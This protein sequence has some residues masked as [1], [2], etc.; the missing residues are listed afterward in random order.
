MSTST[1]ATDAPVSVELP[2]VAIVGRPNVGKSA[3]FNR[4]VGRRQAIVEDLPGTTRDRLYSEVEWRDAHFRVIDTGGLDTTEGAGYPALIRRQVEVAVAEASLLLF[5]VDV[6]DGVLAGDRDVAEILRR[7]SK[8]VFLLV[9]KV[10]NQAREEDAV[11]FYELGLGEPMQLSAQHS[12]GIA[13]V[14][15]RI[16]SSL[17]AP[18]EVLETETL[19]VAIVGR[20]NVG[21]SMLLNA[22]LGEDRV[23]VSPE[24][25]TT[26]DAIDTPFDFQGR[27]LSLIDTAGLRRPGKVREGLEHHASMRARN[28]LDR[29]DT[30]LVVFDASE[31]LTAQ[32][33]HVVGFALKAKTGV[34][35]VANKWDLRSGE[36]LADF[37][38]EVKRK[39]KFAS[40]ASFRITSAKERQGIPQLL[41]E[42]VR[43]SDERKKR[44]DTGQLNSAVQR[45]MVE[46]PP[47]MVKNRRLNLLYVTQ[48]SVAPPLFVFFVNDASLVHFSYRRYLENVLRDKF[49]F[50]GVALRLA[51]RSRREK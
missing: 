25:G 40:W 23:L 19:R 38:R 6:K 32:D 8:P 12:T 11:Q 45:A 29:A 15:D 4:M 26:R 1:E 13:D 2:V 34:I 27:Q 36:E 3:I 41:R 30:A 33:L 24:A 31:G 7:A 35:L 9:N 21:K 47:P 48:P 20:P 46:Q 44:I 43:V 22:I 16:V 5:V 50:E 37:E 18:T 42:A 17:P 14:L 51:F 49:G 10:D 39:L 28:A